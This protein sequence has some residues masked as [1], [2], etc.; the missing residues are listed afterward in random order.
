MFFGDFYPRMDDKGRL[1]LPAKFRDKLR[2]GMVIA[3]G[4]DRC[5]YVYPRAEF[6]R[7]AAQLG[8]AQSTNS[9]VRNYAR[10]LFGG[11]DDQSA[12]KQGRIVIKAALREY[13]GLSRDCAVIGV[14]DKVE[15]WDAEAWRRFAS[16]QEQHYVDFSDEFDLPE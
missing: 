5:L 14:N 7:I 1:A 11:A 6:E 12:D 4:Q 16:E 10:T 15:I 13:A 3:K 9:K 8:K 2:D